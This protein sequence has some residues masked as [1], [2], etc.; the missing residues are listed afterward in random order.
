MKLSKARYEYLIP[1]TRSYFNS[2]SSEK[3]DEALIAIK[4]IAYA[5]TLGL[6]ESVFKSVVLP[7]CVEHKYTFSV[8]LGEIQLK[9]IGKKTHAAELVVNTVSVST[10]LTDA[11]KL[12][13]LMPDFDMTL[14]NTPATIKKSGD[15]V[16]ILKFKL[17]D[18]PDPSGWIGGFS[19][20]RNKHLQPDGT[21]RSNEFTLSSA[22]Y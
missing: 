6:A 14:C 22:Q 20:S 11:P 21:L 5:N 9:P 12:F 3:L 1:E 4:E 17:F 8:A 16:T 2:P 15:K 18:R 7:F 10:G 13:M 19:I